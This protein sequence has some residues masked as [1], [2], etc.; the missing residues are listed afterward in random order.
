[1]CRTHDHLCSFPSSKFPSTYTLAP[2]SNSKNL[3]RAVSALLQ[4]ARVAARRFGV[5]PPASILA[6][7]EIE[8]VEAAESAAA[9]AN[10]SEPSTG[11]ECMIQRENVYSQVSSIHARGNIE[12]PSQGLF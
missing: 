3:K 9:A 12:F 8:A 5:P 11:L 6:E 10:D 4:L 7:L 2:L 1:M